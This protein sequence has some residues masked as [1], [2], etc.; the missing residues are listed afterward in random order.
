MK[1]ACDICGADDAV[2]VPHVREYTGGQV[3][4]ICKSCGF[5]YVRERR[6][7]KEIADVWSKE[8]FGKG[9][10]Y[11]SRTPLML[12]RHNYVA[13]FI[14]QAAGL[15]GKVVCDIG[16]GEGQF[17]NIVKKDYGAEAFG[18]EPSGDNCKTLAGLGIPYFNG[19]CEEYVEKRSPS[20]EIDIVTMMWTLENSTSCN[21]LIKGAW[22]ILKDG[23]YI[24]VATGSRILVPFQ[25]PL[26]MYLSKNPVDAHCFRFSMRSLSSILAK[27]K[28][29]VSKINDYL[30]DG[31]LCVIARKTDKASGIKKDDHKK[32]VEFFEKWHN[33]TK[34]FKG[35]S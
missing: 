14:D 32:V 4:H 9:K 15:R 21:D 12:A 13:E 1:Y 3:I 11:T 7:H 30:N 35:L 2:E 28:F 6:T 10:G 8:L 20:K 27:N 26:D 17:L 22:D 23:G 34:Y 31:I 16:A 5:V 25:K 19:T 33:E 24:V 29:S 18:I